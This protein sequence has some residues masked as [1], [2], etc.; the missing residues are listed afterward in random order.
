MQTVLSKTRQAIKRYDLIQDGDKIAVGVS[1]GK[2]SMLLL[3]TLKTL[4]EFLPQRFTLCAIT[5][6]TNFNEEFADYSQIESF[7]KSI[8]VDLFVERTQ[9]WDIVFKERQ[10]KNPCSLCS[11]MR[12]GALYDTALRLGCNKVA[13]GHHL[14]DV[15]NTFYINLFKN[16][17]LGCFSPLNEIEEKGITV[18]RPFVFVDERDIIHTVNKYNIP[19][20]LNKCIANGCTER[21]KMSETVKRLNA[22]YK[23]I[24]EKTLGAL[25]RSGICG[26]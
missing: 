10:E 15:V 5:I 2:D 9:I 6:D 20:I 1:G 14:D 17:T 19:M 13:L 18:I 16:G 23:D 25:M 3:Q 12:K 24:K 4:S 7:C 8:G 21:A 22:E 11:R 26:W